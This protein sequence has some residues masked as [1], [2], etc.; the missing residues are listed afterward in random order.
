MPEAKLYGAGSENLEDETFIGVVV[1]NRGLTSTLITHLTVHGF[2]SRWAK[3]RGRPDWSA[4]VPQPQFPGNPPNLPGTL[5]P[6]GIWHGHITYSQNM[7]EERDAGRLY[8]GIG[9]SH[10]DK[11]VYRRVPKPDPREEALEGD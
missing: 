6:N 9:G 8:V 10:S 4:F 5:E 3:W 2:S 7:K 1:T 11:V